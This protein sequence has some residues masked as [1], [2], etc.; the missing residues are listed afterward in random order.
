MTFLLTHEYIQT[1]SRLNVVERP[2]PPTTR[3]LT[4]EDRWFQYTINNMSRLILDRRPKRL[5]VMFQVGVDC[6][7]VGYLKGSLSHTTRAF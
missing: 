5:A 2:R 6:F 4:R 1:G 3:R 7:L